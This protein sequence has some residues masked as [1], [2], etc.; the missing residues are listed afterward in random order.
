MVGFFHRNSGLGLSDIIDYLILFFPP[1]FSLRATFDPPH[2]TEFPRMEPLNHIA[3][4]A[5]PI[6]CMWGRLSNFV[7][8]AFDSCSQITS[9]GG[10]CTMTVFELVCIG[11]Y[12]D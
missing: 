5:G 11:Y 2:S 1:F 6:A 10:F 12:Y 3:E 7:S 4:I 8:F 9:A